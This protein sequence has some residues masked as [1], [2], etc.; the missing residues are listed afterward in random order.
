MAVLDL[1]ELRMQAAARAAQAG[2]VPGLLGAAEALRQAMGA[3][4]PAP[5]PVLPPP[6]DMHE[7]FHVP[8]PPV[9]DVLPGLEPGEVGLLV[10]TGGSGKTWMDLSIAEA[11]AM[12]TPL[13]GLDWWPKAPPSN[14]MLLAGEDRAL[15]LRRRLHAIGQ[16]DPAAG[17]ALEQHLR[18]WPLVGT[19]PA[20]IDL[21]GPT[22][23]YHAV[24][25]EAQQRQ[26]R[27]IIIDPAAKFHRLD[28]NSNIDMERFIDLLAGLGQAAGSAVLVAHHTSKGAVQAGGAAA[29]SQ[30]SSRGASAL[31]D[32]SR[33]TATLR[34]L[35]FM[36]ATAIG[37][38]ATWRTARLVKFPKLNNSA[39]LPG[40]L[41]EHGDGGILSLI[42]EV[43]TEQEA[44]L[45]EVAGGRSKGANV[46]WNEGKYAKLPTQQP[47]TSVQ[48]QA[49]VERLLGTAKGGQ[50]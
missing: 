37:L 23:L 3:E 17:A 28:E 32:A 4:V 41:L 34:R 35:T 31:V 11:V 16:L 30:H 14:V 25:D 6:M 38:D 7:V 44:L 43:D 9:D 42:N 20:L 5:A 22:D 33:W 1:T 10:A 46:R 29:E 19:G 45:A 47:T 48:E 18:I 27:L 49:A 36:E 21:N 24:R 13:F 26:P 15:R 12:G 50:Q 40:V 8:P 2:D 39:D